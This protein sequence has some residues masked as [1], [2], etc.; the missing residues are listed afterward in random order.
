MHINLPPIRERESDIILLAQHFTN[1]FC[2]EN[3]MPL[4]EISQDAKKILLNYPFPGNVREIKSIMELA[5]VLTESKEYITADSINLDPVDNLQGLLTQ[6]FTMKEYYNNIILHFLK[7]Y[8]NNVLLVANK[9]DIGKST[10]YRLIS[11]D[12]GK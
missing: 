10:I 5:V 11:D 7:K 6:E 8:N 1:A 3:N 2:K 4:L 9:L 12:K